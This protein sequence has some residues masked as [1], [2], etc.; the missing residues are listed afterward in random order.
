[1]S[2]SHLLRKFSH[3]NPARAAPADAERDPSENS[4]ELPHARRYATEPGPT[5]SRLWAWRASSTDDRF[6]SSMT[7]IP[8]KSTAET[9]TLGAGI[10]E[11]PLAGP[12]VLQSSPSMEF[13]QEMT[14]PSPVLA[15]D[16]LTETWSLVKRGIS[17]SD[18]NQRLNA[19]GTPGA[20][21]ISAQSFDSGHQMTRLLRYRTIFRKSN[22]SLP[23]LQAM[24]RKPPL[25][26]P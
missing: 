12:S 26:S 22:L 3:P 19:F 13:D 16:K 4:Y 18:L 25:S 7:L 6:S 10:C 24:L 8:R 21:F 5:G 14:F 17:D 11:E 15:S 23:Q 20:Y 1:M 9:S 2:F